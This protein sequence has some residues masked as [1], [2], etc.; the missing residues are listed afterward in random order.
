[1]KRLLAVLLGALLLIGAVALA[2]STAPEGKITIS[3]G[4]AKDAV[5]DHTAHV[6][7]ADTCQKC[8]HKDAAGAEQKCTGCHT[9]DGKDG[10]PAAKTA[11]H[12]LCGGCHKEMGK[13]PQYPRGCKECHAK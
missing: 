4:G 3:T 10:A 13:G 7:R 11:F 9:E 6:A 2:A 1:M 12:K 5:F 8:H